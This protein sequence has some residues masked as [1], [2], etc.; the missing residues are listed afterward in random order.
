MNCTKKLPQSLID[1]IDQMKQGADIEWIYDS[2]GEV[3]GV[4][5][6]TQTLCGKPIKGRVEF[7]NGQVYFWKYS[8]GYFYVK[9]DDEWIRIKDPLWSPG[10]ALPPNFPRLRCYYEKQRV[11]EYPKC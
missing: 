4:N 8:G 9:V 11:L 1:L 5:A 10:D 7:T 3:I 2:N 6:I